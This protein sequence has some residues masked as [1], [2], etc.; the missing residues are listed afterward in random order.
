VESP[1]R[2]L[3]T[4]ATRLSDALLQ[5]RVLKTASLREV[6]IKRARPDTIILCDVFRYFR[7][8]D[9]RSNVFLK[10]GDMIHLPKRLVSIVVSGDVTYPDRY[11]YRAGDSLYT[12]LN[13]AGGLL[14]SALLDSVNIIRYTPNQ[15]TTETITLDIRSMNPASNIPLKSGDRIQVR[16]IPFWQ[17]DESVLVEGRV[18]LPGY[19]RIEKGKTTLKELI[20]RAGGFIEFASLEEAS[21]TRA[22]AIRKDYSLAD[23]TEKDS[24]DEDYQYNLARSREP[25]GRMVC[26]F[27]KLFL[28]NDRSQN[29]ALE[30]GDVIRVPYFKRY[31]N[32][33]GR[34]QFPGNI[35]YESGKDAAFYIEKAGGFTRRAKKGDVLILKPNTKELI[36][37][38]DVKTIEPSDVILVQEKGKPTFWRDA[39]SVFRDTITVVGAVATTILLVRN[40]SP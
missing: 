35:E 4:A 5:S 33:I 12:A 10:E 26:D 39:W 32:V 37:A 22:K 13:L 2:I 14:E 27:K 29:I 8:L 7:L 3:V 9:S 30:E 40:L 19:Y 6:V 20:E 17:P 28:E 1:A 31:V 21:V 15:L 16:R 23:F 25:E 34:V 18:L 11:A 36:E 38:G 24:D